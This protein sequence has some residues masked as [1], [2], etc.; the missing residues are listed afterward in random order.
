M[1][2]PYY[3]IL[4]NDT[5]KIKKLV[6]NINYR[7]RKMGLPA[8]LSVE[9]L[10]NI[11]VQY[12]GKCA[13]T[14][15]ELY[16]EDFTTDHFIP[17]DWKIVGS[18]KENIV[19]MKGGINSYKKNMSPFEFY[20]RFTMFGRRDCDENWNNL[21]TYMRKMYKFEEK[22]DFFS[23]IR[24]CWFI[25]KNPHYFLMVGQPLEIVKNMYLSIMDKYSIDGKHNY[26]T[27]KAMRELDISFFLE[28]KILKTEW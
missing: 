25:Q 13:V 2:I 15:R 11:L 1:K 7:A 6:W 8:S 14:K 20:Y 22:V 21:I 27:H 9:E 23:F 16:A 10:T 12:E 18:C 28:N 3:E 4:L 19:P 26:Y 24:F 17:L 5:K